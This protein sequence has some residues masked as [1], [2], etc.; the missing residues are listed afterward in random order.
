[1]SMRFGD[2]GL[3]P[4]GRDFDVFVFVQPQFEFFVLLADAVE[5]FHGVGFFFDA[6]GFGAV[7]E[8]HDGGFGGAFFFNGGRDGFFASG[9]FLSGFLT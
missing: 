4:D 3:G 7:F 6:L 5:E 1:M 8:L 2:I 9:F